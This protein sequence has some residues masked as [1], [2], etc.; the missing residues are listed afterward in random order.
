[1]FTAKES[2]GNT[3]ITSPLAAQ[4]CQMVP[5]VS[6]DNNENDPTDRGKLCPANQLPDGSASPNPSDAGKLEIIACYVIV[7]DECREA[8]LKNFTKARTNKHCGTG[9]KNTF[10]TFQYQSG[11]VAAMPII[12]MCWQCLCLVVLTTNKPKQI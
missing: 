12:G 4:F 5:A 10:A 6:S 8:Q 7:D 2:Q 1:M 11:D 3:T 9:F